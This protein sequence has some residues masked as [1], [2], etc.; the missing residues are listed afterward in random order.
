VWPFTT[1]AQVQAWQGTFRSSGQQPW[2]LDPD[3]TALAFCR[4]H[5]GYLEIDLV[6]TRS[7]AGADARLGVGWKGENGSPHTVGELHLVRFGPEQDAPWVVVGSDDTTLTL[8]TP[9]YG[10]AVTS[11]LTVGG[12]ITGVDESLRVKVLGPASSTPLAEVAGIP[13]GGENT[14]WTTT[15]RFVA[16]A[17]TVLTVA[18]STGGHLMDVERFAITAVRVA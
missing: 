5:L 18:V 3:R 10:T 8:S 12:R 1:P 11:P 4:D 17:G 6:T 2:H 9:G 16:P 13:A 14:P 7:V 15:L